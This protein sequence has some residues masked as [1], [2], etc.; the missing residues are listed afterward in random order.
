VLKR[1]GF[2]LV[3]LLVGLT[4]VGL[5]GTATARL[6]RSMYGTSGAQV[7]IA[8]TQSMVRT[9]VLALSQDFRELGIDVGPGGA[10]EADLE[11]I[12]RNRVTYRAMRGIGIVCSIP[13][14]TEFRVRRPWLGMRE[15]SRLDGFLLFVENDPRTGSDDQWVPFRVVGIDMRSRCGGDPAVALTLAAPPIVDSVTATALTLAQVRVGAPIRWF[16]RIEYG[17]VVDLATGR[18]FVGVRSISRG[19]TVLTPVFGPLA[20]T[21][22]L[23]LTY[24]DA[25]N[26]PLDPAIAAPTAVRSIGVRIV[27]VTKG[28]VSLAGTTLRRPDTTTIEARV[29]L[30]NTLQP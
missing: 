8:T 11:A 25:R 12:G 1:R 6:L 30:R 24:A 10:L 13:S 16:E 15:P 27:G 2:S 14:L 3:E 9:G 4:L 20:D 22:G 29:A 21:A 7:A 18:P 26:L 28:P 19:E 23:Q 5:I 17:P